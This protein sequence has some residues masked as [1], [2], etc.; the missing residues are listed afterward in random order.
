MAPS[1]IL[2]LLE[3]AARHSNESGITFYA[4]GNVSEVSKRLTYSDLLQLARRNALMIGQMPCTTPKTKYL[5]HFDNHLDGIEFF[6]SIIVGG[7]VPAISTPFTSDTE[8]RKKHLSHLQTLLDKPVIITRR[9][10]LSQFAGLREQLNIWTIEEIQSQHKSSR[11]A[12]FRA[13]IAPKQDDIAVLMLTSGSTGNAKA[14]G[15]RHAQVIESIKGKAAHHGTRS[16]DVFLNWIG[17]D[18]VANLTE[19]HLHAMSLAAEQVQVG[20]ADMIANPIAFIKLLNKHS[21][22][23]TFAPS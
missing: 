22:A 12:F 13:P 5:L 20:A 1:N 8:Q 17:L 6:W 7:L 11:P 10:L 16:S 15:L 2:E 9:H 3:E 18:H 14:V 23:Y 21:V 4:P 19:I